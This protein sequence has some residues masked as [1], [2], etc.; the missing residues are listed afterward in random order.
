MPRVVFLLI[1]GSGFMTFRYFVDRYY[2]KREAV[3]HEFYDV[4]SFIIAA[5]NEDALSAQ[6]WRELL[7]ICRFA[8][9]RFRELYDPEGPWRESCEV[10]VL[11]ILKRFQ[12]V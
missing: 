2:K 10:F 12:E 4:R 8:D 1:M 7:P 11:Q 3:M 6:E 9:E 5:L